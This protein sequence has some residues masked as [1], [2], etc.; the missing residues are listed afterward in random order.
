MIAAVLAGAVMLA[1]LYPLA[2]NMD[3]ADQAKDADPVR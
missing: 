2:R 3:Q 1:C